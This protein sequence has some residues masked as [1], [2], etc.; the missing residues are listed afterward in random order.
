MIMRI[1]LLSL[2]VLFALA[3][4]TVGTV[5]AAPPDDTHN[6]RT[7]LSGEEAGVEDTL[8]Q[9]Q[10]IFQF[11]KDGEELYY[12]L[13]VANIEDVTMA[14]IHVAPRG[15]QNGPPVLWLY[16]DGPPPQLI[17]DRSNGVLAERTVTAADLVGPL[18]GKYFADLKI[19]IEEGRAY[20][21]VHTMQNPGG[22]IRGTIH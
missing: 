20:V 8:A 16:P 13:I 17:E 22:E 1:R 9:G 10:A 21:N 2:F 12:K 15:L 19:A 11:S 6:F 18:A 5:A 14:H 7:H 4:T 3:V